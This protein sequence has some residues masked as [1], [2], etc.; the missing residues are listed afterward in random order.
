MNRLWIVFLFLLLSVFMGC[1]K[2][3]EGECAENLYFKESYN[4]LGI[5]NDVC[6]RLDVYSSKRVILTAYT[7]QHRMPQLYESLLHYLDQHQRLYYSTD[8][9]HCTINSSEAPWVHLFGLNEQECEDAKSH[10]AFTPKQSF[11]NTTPYYVEAFTVIVFIVFLCFFV[12][13]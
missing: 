6:S 2:R 13:S 5:S 4:C 1:L 11:T 12:V 9:V 10:L 7:H 8:S 3:I